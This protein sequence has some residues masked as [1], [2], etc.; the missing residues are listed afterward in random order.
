MRKSIACLFLASIFLL[1]CRETPKERISRDYFSGADTSNYYPG[2]L[3][4]ADT[5]TYDVIVKNPVPE[6]EWM[7]K[8]LEDLERNELIDYLFESVYTGDL[9]AYDVFSGDE[10]S[11][12]EV[13]EIEK[14]P[15][16]SRDKI[17]KIQFTERWFFKPTDL[18]LKKEVLAMVLGYETY[19]ED[20][21]VWGYKPVFKIYLNR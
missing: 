12:R 9:I 4:I 6:D 15:D 1:G 14:N 19:D 8:S 2:H 21:L 5:I 13:E 11:I 7:K 3:I 10:L 20:G 16:F 17:G 18:S